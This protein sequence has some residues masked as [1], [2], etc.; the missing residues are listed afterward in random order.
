[1][2]TSSHGILLTPGIIQP[3]DLRFEP[4]D[5]HVI[6]Y[7]QGHPAYEAVEAMIRRRPAQP[8]RVRA[9]LTRHD[10]TQVDHLNDAAACIEAQVFDSRQTVYR[11]I[12]VTEEGTPA[13]PCVTVRF[14]SFANETIELH[15]E[16]ASPPDV[17]RGGLTDPG[18]HAPTSSLPLM[19]RGK[20][21]LAGL[22]TTVRIDGVACEVAERVRSPLGFV[23]LHG[24]YTEIHQM[25]AVRASTACVRGRARAIANR[26]G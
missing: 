25:G 14:T 1:M 9:I 11:D 17:A 10:Q 8:S 16:T 7:M 26:A 23:G 20:S 6:V 5:L 12:D 19:W 2:T 22:G 18:G 13:R 4:D 24:F 21:C 3:F 15:L